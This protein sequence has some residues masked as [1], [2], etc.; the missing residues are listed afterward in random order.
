LR[1]PAA[2]EGFINASVNQTAREFKT[3]LVLR[4]ATLRHSPQNFFNH[5][6]HGFHG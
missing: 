6:L 2:T 5:G 4:L 3:L 1:K